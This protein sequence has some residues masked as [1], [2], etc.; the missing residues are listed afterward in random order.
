MKRRGWP[1]ERSYAH[2]VHSAGRGVD[3][4]ILLGIP[5]DAPPEARGAIIDAELQRVMA[6]LSVTVDNAIAD[7]VARACE[8]QASAGGR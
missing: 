7:L 3:P 2:A 8:K 4:Q 6:L 5:E 1:W